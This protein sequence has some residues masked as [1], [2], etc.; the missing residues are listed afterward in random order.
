MICVLLLTS[1]LSLLA[2][3]SM[4]CPLLLES[5]GE[6]SLGEREEKV[7]AMEMLGSVS[8]MPWISS[9]TPVCS[10]VR[11]CYQKERGNSFGQVYSRRWHPGSSHV[12]KT[13]KAIPVRN[14]QGSYLF[15]LANKAKSYKNH[16][17]F[18]PLLHWWIFCPTVCFHHCFLV[19]IA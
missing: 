10:G 6:I 11:Q 13:G 8:C 12:S 14:V 3:H 7:W 19:Y 5:D 2:A 15:A 17:C 18:V 1:V 16:E 4:G 9:F